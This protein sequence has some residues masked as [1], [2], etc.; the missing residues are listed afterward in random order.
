MSWLLFFV[1]VP[2]SIG[3]LEE[4]TFG[5]YDSS[6]VKC[7]PALLTIYIFRYVC[8]V[9]KVPQ[10]RRMVAYL[11]VVLLL[12]PYVYFIIDVDHHPFR[13]PVHKW[14]FDPIWIFTI[15]TASFLTMD[16]REQN[17]SLKT[18]LIFTVLELTIVFY[19]WT[20]LWIIWTIYVL[21]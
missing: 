17:Y 20:H 9:R 2:L 6:I 7:Y 3:T 8:I 18:F 15:P 11:F 21:I 1:S 13:L 12:L 10:R 4:G 14:L 16:L 19:L 5:V